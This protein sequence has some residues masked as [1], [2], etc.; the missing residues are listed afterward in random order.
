MVHG[1]EKRR[2]DRI[3]C[4]MPFFA[5]RFSRP[6]LDDPA[7]YEA[8]N[9]RPASYMSAP[10]THAINPQPISPNIMAVFKLAGISTMWAMVA[11]G[12]GGSKIDVMDQPAWP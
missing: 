5:R 7:S 10:I 4:F 1:G 6:R 12:T 9:N 3:V 8:E 2:A 11:D